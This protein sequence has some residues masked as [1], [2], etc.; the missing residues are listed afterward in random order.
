MSIALL[1][2]PA[3]L[4]R[5]DERGDVEHGAREGDDFAV[6]V[7]DRRG[8]ESNMANGAVRVQKPRFGGERGPGVGRVR[9]GR[10]GEID[11][12][13]VEAGGELGERDRCRKFDTRELTPARIH[14]REGL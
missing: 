1:A 10:Y 3:G 6:L 2:P 8:F 4:G 7:G 14:E 5:F 9:E 13:A 12:V 11:V